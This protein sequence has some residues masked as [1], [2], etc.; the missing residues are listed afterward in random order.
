MTEYRPADNGEEHL[1]LTPVAQEGVDLLEGIR[2]RGDPNAYQEVQALLLTDTIKQGPDD[3]SAALNHPDQA[4]GP[5]PEGVERD[6]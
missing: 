3:D 2:R 1:E 5:W 6:G 4:P